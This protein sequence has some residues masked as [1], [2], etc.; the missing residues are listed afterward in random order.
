VDSEAWNVRYARRGFLWTSDPNRFLVAETSTL[1]CGRALDLACGEGRNTVW[2]AER[3]WQVIGVDFSKVA[4]K[5]A[6]GLADARGVDADWIAADLLDYQP[7]HRAFELVLL[8]YLQVPSAQRH[9]IVR[10]AAQAVAPGGVFLLVG[11]DSSNL[12]D[13]HGGPSNPAVLYTAPEI[14]A[15][16]QGTG[17]RIDRAEPVQRTVPTPEGDRVARDA[18]VRARR[19]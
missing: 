16:L 3:G 8:F 11:H 7:E 2:L 10:A 5:K 9:T 4:L 14:A 13:G 19:P 1:A 18:L 15:D 6:R 17:L 12:G